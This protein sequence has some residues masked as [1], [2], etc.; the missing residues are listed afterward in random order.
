MKRRAALLW[1]VGSLWLAMWSVARFNAG[2]ATAYDL[3]I[4]SQ[5]AKS[6]SQGHWP[7]SDIRGLDLLGDHFSPILALNGLWW[8]IWPDPRV[9]LIAQAILLALAM[10]IVWWVARTLVGEP[11]A[12]LL[13][14][15]GLVARGTIAADLFDFHEVAY[16]APTVALLA[17]AV[18][19]ARFRLAV[20]S[21]VVL[22]LVKEDLGLTVIAAG[23]AWWLLHRDGWRRPAVL[24]SVGVAGLVAATV[25]LRAVGGGS[26]YGVFFGGS[27]STPLGQQVDTGWSWWRLAP[28]ALFAVTALFVGLRSPVAVLAIPTLAWRMIGNNP[29]YWRLDTHYDLVLVPI[30]LIAAAHALH[31]PT[32]THPDFC[33]AAHPEAALPGELRCKTPVTSGVAAVAGIGAVISVT[34]GVAQLVEV[35]AAPWHA[36]APTQRY[37]D[38]QEISARISKGA[39]I[40]ASNTT[41]AYL[42]ATHDQ[43]WS[44]QSAP[45]VRYVVF[46]RDKGPLDEVSRCQ[47][48]A[49]FDAATARADVTVMTAGRGDIIAI[50]YLDPTIVRLADC[51]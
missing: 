35:A 41:G 25:V 40:A 44:I 42:V 12:L 30:A 18:L 24:V 2:L 4:F 22:V 29:S 34:L 5:S 21:A 31:G 9:L 14:V 49:L 15:I 37:R 45:A 10:V 8:R 6:W 28:L 38:L 27:G 46:A 13:F 36:V 7:R 23:A 20:A 19:R 43:V 51:G 32:H 33:S 47:R 1:L 48:E 50:R 11:I 26:G 17:A 3:G 16:A 39:P